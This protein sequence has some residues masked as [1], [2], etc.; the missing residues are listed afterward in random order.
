MSDSERYAAMAEDMVRKAAQSLNR[1][2]RHGYLNLADEWRR[3][4][5]SAAA[6][7]AKSAVSV[8]GEVIAF[9]QAEDDAPAPGEDDERRLP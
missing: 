8:E 7:E 2:E 6:F 4:S 5:H 1:V 3:L 9:A